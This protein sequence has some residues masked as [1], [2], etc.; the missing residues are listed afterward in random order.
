MLLNEMI[1]LDQWL[2]R[3]END[4]Q[5]IAKLA[6]L[7][8]I[9]NS[10]IQARAPNNR[11][12]PQPIRA[13]SK[14]KTEAIDALR[15]YDLAELSGDQI[16]CISIHGA[17]QYMGNTAAENLIEVFRN[18]VHDLAYL[19]KEVTAIH[20]AINTAKTKIAAVA[21]LAAP[22]S[23][24]ISEAQYFKDKA[25]FSIIF[26]DGVKVENLNDLESRA[27][28]WSK[29]MHGIGLALDIPPNEFKVLG[30]R[31][32]SLVIDLF[33][34]AP[35]IIPIGFI[36]DR[37]FTI[38]EKFALSMKKLKGIYELD[39]DDPGFQ[40]IEKQVKETSDRYFNLQKVVTAKKLADEILD[41]AKCPNEKRAEAQT[42]L[43][44]SIKRI[45][46]H[47]RKGGDLDAF[48]PDA[49]SQDPDSS[50]SDPE[51]IEEANKLFE[52]F[53]HRKINLSKSELMELLE[54]FDFEEEA[55]E[56]EE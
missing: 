29:I 3:K 2:T 51:K 34:Y 16:T 9:L 19:S 6:A 14:E 17:D 1:N 35:A 41:D 36:L 39:L 37:T 42:F 40:E 15:T 10:N 54:H 48:I 33:M 43:E 27:K 11:N 44:T 45:L 31:N 49:N 13:F 53:R 4:Y 23:E 21:L 28:E 25:R 46:N 50:D 5:P 20:K 47:L 56:A 24:A 32:G 7:L 22:Y 38:I 26:K 8:A 12:Q 55:E 30:A 52:S 18:E